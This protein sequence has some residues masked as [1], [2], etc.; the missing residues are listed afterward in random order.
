MEQTVKFTLS[1]SKM[2]KPDWIDDFLKSSQRLF[3][4]HDPKSHLPFFAWGLFPHYSDLW[5]EKLYELVKSF[6]RK[7]LKIEEHLDSFPNLSSTRFILLLAAIH[8]QLTTLNNPKLITSVCNFLIDSIKLRSKTGL[9]PDDNNVEYSEAELE[10]LLKRRPLHEASLEESREIGKILAA[11]AS[12]VH[13]LHN[14]WC[15][16][17]SYEIT[18]PYTHQHKT[19]LV[20][21]FADLKPTEIWPEADWNFKDISI[22]TSYKDL[23]A[24]IIYVGCHITYDR[25]TVENLSRFNFI[26]DGKEI[27]NVAGLKALREKLMV[28][29]TNQYEKYLNMDFESQKEKFLYQ[30]HYQLKKLF[31]IAGLDWK[32][33]REILQRI[34]GKKLIENI[35][36]TYDLTKR[37]Y[38]KYFG[39]DKLIAA[40]KRKVD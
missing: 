8:Y 17:L 32:P 28:V 33:S 24:E 30:E 5:L 7:G 38:R 26:V 1:R 35:F 10:A 22:L 37:E 23:S 21:S 12:L 14:D 9:F 20:R 36:P 27:T 31:E 13:G 3:A 2:A 40:Y 16:D 6:R 39:G 15:T 4:S 34:K 18:G 19:I 29:A 25:S 11:L